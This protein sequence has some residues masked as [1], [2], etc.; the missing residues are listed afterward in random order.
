MLAAILKNPIVNCNRWETACESLGIEYFTVDTAKSNY[1]DL[2]KER[3]PDFCLA[4]PSGLTQHL[5]RVYDERIYIVE[6]HLKIPVFPSHNEI[7]LH[8]NKIMLT[9]FLKA[10]GL[11]HAETFVSFNRDESINFTENAH[12]PFVA[13]TS[14][15]AAG[16]GV[17]IIKNK[18]QARK[19][20]KQA[21]TTGIKRRFGPNPKVGSKKSWLQKALK[22]PQFF[23]NKLKVYSLRSGDIQKGYVIFQQ[24]IEHDFEWRCVKIGE[25][26]FAYKKLKVGDKASGSK[27]FDYGAP[28]LEL[29]DF[30]KDLC[31]KHEFNFMAVDLFYTEGKIYI[32]ELQTLFGHKNPFICKVNNEQGRFLYKENTWVF[33]KGE[34]NQNESYNL[35]LKE[36]LTILKY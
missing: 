1:I 11:P 7:I 30:T 29:L 25:S 27:I 3:K 21:F 5:K 24:Y 8:E 35:R 4:R 10:E 34:F 22:S 17:I 13:K 33:E 32:N 26:Y 20:I 19:Y 15:G 2:L 36:I 23:L 31:E 6:K 28:P 18:K 12:F 16:S 9:S 14:N